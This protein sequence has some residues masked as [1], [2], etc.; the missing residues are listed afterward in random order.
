MIEVSDFEIELC[1]GKTEAHII[2]ALGLLK[3]I[4]IRLGKNNIMV[5]DLDKVKK[6]LGEAYKCL[7]EE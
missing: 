1:G 7:K 4:E 2:S 3:E 5:L 6:H